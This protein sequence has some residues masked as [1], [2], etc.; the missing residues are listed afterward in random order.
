MRLFKHAVS[1]GR[2]R[3]LHAVLVES[4]TNTK[5]L[6]AR[7]EA[8]VVVPRITSGKLFASFTSARGGN[9]RRYQRSSRGWNEHA[10]SYFQLSEGPNSRSS[11]CRC[12]E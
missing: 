3:S 4:L 7:L 9:C 6:L 5:A 2:Q 8:G 12:R 11:F 1:Q 10:Q